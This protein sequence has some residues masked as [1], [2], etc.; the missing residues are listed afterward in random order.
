MRRHKPEPPQRGRRTSPQGSAMVRT[1]S[2]P[3]SWTTSTAKE[4]WTNWMERL[5]GPASAL[6]P[7]HHRHVLTHCDMERDQADSSSFKMNVHISCFILS[8][9]RVISDPSDQVNRNLGPPEGPGTSTS[10]GHR[11]L[12]HESQSTQKKHPKYDET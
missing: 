6:R 9:R 12:G 5:D 10:E 7:E 4:T 3:T 8:L 2:Q 1:G 11:G